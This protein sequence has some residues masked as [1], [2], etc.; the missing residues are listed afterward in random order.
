MIFSSSNKPIKIKCG[1]EI[2]QK[3]LQQT[4]HCKECNFSFKLIDKYIDL[5]VDLFTLEYNQIATKQL[6][7]ENCTVNLNTTLSDITNFADDL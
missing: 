6:N 3:C 2:C 5:E 7:H 1:H 4:S